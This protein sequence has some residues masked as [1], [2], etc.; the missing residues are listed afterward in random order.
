MP[1]CSSTPPPNLPHVGRRESCCTRGAARS[2]TLARAV[3]LVVFGALFA[4]PAAREQAPLV[5]RMATL[6]PDGSTWHLILKETGEKWKA[7]SG[8][9]SRFGSSRG[10]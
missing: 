1:W 4:A 2:S 6:V 5:V 9:G 3:G 8:A 10:G 7:V